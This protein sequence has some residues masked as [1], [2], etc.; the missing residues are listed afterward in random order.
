MFDDYSD[1]GKKVDAT[2]ENVVNNFY[3]KLEKVPDGPNLPVNLPAENAGNLTVTK[4][5]SGSS[6]SGPRDPDGNKNFGQPDSHRKR[7]C[8]LPGR[9]QQP[10]VVD[11]KTTREAILPLIP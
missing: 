7:L 8:L 6:G 5:I 3:T 11:E 2:A 9:F 10:A 1:A 4:M